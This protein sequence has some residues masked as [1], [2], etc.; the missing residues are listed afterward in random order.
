M[1]DNK[2]SSR[3]AAA[4]YNIAR[5]TLQRF[6]KDPERSFHRPPKYFT[7][8]EEANI[9]NWITQ[10][11]KR[12][13]PRSR[14]DI[15]QEVA[16]MNQLKNPE[17]IVEP[18]DNWFRLFKRRHQLKVRKAESLSRASGNVTKENIVK[19]FSTVESGLK[20]NQLHHLLQRPDRCYNADESYF[21]LNPAKGSVVVTND[22]KTVF[23]LRKNEKAGLTV[24]LTIRADAKPCRPFVI[25]T[26]KR[27]PASISSSFPHD[28]A[29]I[30][31]SESGWMT[32]DI[33]CDFLLC[34][35]QQAKSDGVDLPNDKI[36]LYVDNHSTHITQQSCEKASEL[37][38]VLITFYPNATYLYQPCDKT[39]FR[40]LKT[41]FKKEVELAKSRIPDR[42]ITDAS[43][44]QVFMK[45]YKKFAANE[46]VTKNGFR[47]SGIFP[48]DAEAID[49]SKCLGKNRA[50]I[51]TTDA[52]EL[53]PDETDENPQEVIDLSDESNASLIREENLRRVMDDPNA[54]LMFRELCRRELASILSKNVIEVVE[55]QDIEPE[56]IIVESRYVEPEAVIEP[57][58]VVIVE[59]RNIEPEAMIEPGNVESHDVEANAIQHDQ[60]FVIPPTPERLGKRAVKRTSPLVSSQENILRLKTTAAEKQRAQEEK[61]ARLHQRL[62][63]REI[64][65][66]ADAEKLVKLRQKANLNSSQGQQPQVQL[67]A[68]KN[69]N[70]RPLQDISTNTVSKNTESSSTKLISYFTD[71]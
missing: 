45:A 58:N 44:S 29:D 62:L 36:L 6:F 71:G 43:F 48:W 53:E 22:F 4:K 13:F 12:G 27:I 34:L 37:G 3:K 31:A 17:S 61:E 39:C 56:F 21:L 11:A 41:H 68:K 14:R 50:I 59:S 2:M 52:N 65:H 69:S 70:K 33:F 9:V 35:A 38:I 47:A 32:S 40:S 64:K 51:Q 49:F 24:M 23:E 5:T 60:L 25:Y 67:S 18:G 28:E 57:E 42:S 55:G 16:S 30:A 19:W 10:C 54:D 63:A 1:R 46:D 15:L 66:K 8:S 26:H 20:E 7:T